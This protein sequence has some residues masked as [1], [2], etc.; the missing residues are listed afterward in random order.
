MQKLEVVYTND[1]NL[2]VA[3][4]SFY[5]LLLEYILRHFENNEKE[6]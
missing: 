4:D 2:N 1:F 5:S 6:V 3:S